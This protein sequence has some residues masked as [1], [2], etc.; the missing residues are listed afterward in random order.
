MTSLTTEEIMDSIVSKLRKNKEKVAG[1]TLLNHAYLKI[2]E[3]EQD[4][5]SPELHVT[6]EGVEGGSLVNGVV[7]PKPKIWTMFMFFYTGIIV[8]FIFGGALGV[9]QW[10]LGMNAPWLWSIPLA[11]FLWLVVF[12][13]AKFGQRQA[14]RQMA[15]LRNFLDLAL[16]EAESKKEE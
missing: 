11:A 14:N 15:R 2:P 5:W 4:Y 13:A 16:E 1:D 12:L 7:G 9:S 3:D 8:I 6:V 10:M